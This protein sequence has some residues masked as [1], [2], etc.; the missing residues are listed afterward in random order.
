MKEGYLAWEVSYFDKRQGTWRIYA[1][2]ES[3]HSAE[4][5]AGLLVERLGPDVKV[6]VDW[7]RPA[8]AMPPGRLKDAPGQK[9]LFG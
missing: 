3:Q 9:P 2:Y 1:R 8:P 5:A 7:E 6:R 4:C